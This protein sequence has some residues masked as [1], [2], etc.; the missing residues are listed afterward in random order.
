MHLRLYISIA[1]A[2]TAAAGCR[3]AEGASREK[4]ATDS[5]RADSIARARQDSINRTQP[6]YIVDSARSPE[7]DLRRF[8]A[9]LGGEPA[10]RLAGGSS[11]SDHLIRRLV[12]A[13]AARDT[14]AMRSMVLTA[15]EYADLV[16]P[17]SPYMRPPYAQ[18]AALAWMQIAHASVSG[19]KRLI[20]RRG[21]IRFTLDGYHCDPAVKREGEN[22]L[23]SGCVL[24]LS[25]PGVGSATERWFGSIIERDGQF[26][27]V[28]YANQF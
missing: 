21:G 28:S 8:R 18:P 2:L 10:A 6:G 5:A 11:S 15:R 14:A 26:K 24:R 25:A 12:E 1:L 20:E 16:Y 9:M 19:F 13:V 23:R 4:S 7:E 22:V 27:F 3:S 17:S